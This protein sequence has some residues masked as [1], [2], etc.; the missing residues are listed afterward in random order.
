L[1]NSGN[2][3]MRDKCAIVGI[4]QTDFSKDSGRSEKALACEAI[5]KA[6]DNAGLSP[7]DVDGVVKYTDDST[8][9]LALVSALGI[10]NLK[11][12]GESGYG[13]SSHCAVVGHAAAAVA[14]GTANVV[15]CFRGL[16]ERSGRRFGLARPQTSIGGAKAFTDP[17]GMLSPAHRFAMFARRHMVEYGTTSEQFGMVAV[18]QR[19]NAQHNPNAMMFGR[20]MTL[21][22][23]QRSRMITDPMRLFDCCLESDGAVA[24]IVTS[25]ARARDLAQPVVTISGYAQGT[26]PA[27]DGIVFRPDLSVSEAELTAADVYRAAGVAPGD[28]DVAE[29]YDH[30]SPFVIFALEAYGFCAKG[31]G[32]PFIESGYTR[33]PDGKIPVNTHGGNLSEAYI[34]GLTHVAEAVRQLRGTAYCQVPGAEIA[35][36]GSAVAQVSSALILRRDSGPVA[37]ILEHE[38]RVSEWASESG[39]PPRTSRSG[40]NIRPQTLSMSE[41]DQHLPLPIVDNDSA[42]FWEGCRERKLLLQ[43]C[44][45]CA[46]FRYPP[47]PVCSSCR[48]MLFE[49]VESRGSG[50]VYSWTIAHHPVHPAV[51]GRVPYNIV[52]VE[53]DEGPRLVTNLVDV[54]GNRI[55]AGMCVKVDY[56]EVADGFVLPVFRPRQQE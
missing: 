47:Q 26:G 8:S 48:S 11:Y 36:V 53:L 17:F 16:N 33:W 52:L 1:R 39:P 27:A 19:A 56:L 28:V 6:L 22:D 3:G 15:V 7:D 25:T 20:T 31:E 32:G 29:F 5:L 9:E 30:F 41:N 14:T 46:T 55:H 49:W 24:V 43:R 13:G 37:E 4:G 35:L 10:P 12:F 34:H 40:S 44:S 51:V 2:T 50:S 54:P 38:G 45:S 21:E 23:H 18:N 42:T